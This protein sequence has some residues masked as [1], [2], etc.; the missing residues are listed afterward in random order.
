MERK[1]YVRLSYM[2]ICSGYKIKWCIILTVISHINLNCMKRLVA[3]F[4][5]RWTGFNPGSGQVG[6]VVDKVASGQVFS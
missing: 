5:P 6:F 1:K 2:D 4:P 3:G